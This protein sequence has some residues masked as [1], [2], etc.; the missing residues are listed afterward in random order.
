[1]VAF[2]LTSSFSEI[3][4]TQSTFP[5]QKGIFHTPP[6]TNPKFD[7]C[8]SVID[9]Y[10]TSDQ[11]F[12]SDSQTCYSIT[13]ENTTLITDDD[14]EREVNS[15]RE[16]PSELSRLVDFFISDLKQPKYSRPLNIEQLSSIFQGFYTKFDKSSFQYLSVVNVNG[17]NNSNVTTTFFNARETLCSGL[18]GLFARSRSSS[19]SSLMRARR[20][21]SLLNNDSNSVTPMLSPEEIKKQLKFNELLNLKIDK[22]MELCETEVFK[23]ILEVG[24]AVESTYLNEDKNKRSHSNKRTF[25]VSNLFKNS[26]EYGIYSKLLDRK[27]NCLCELDNE[28]RIDLKK[29]LDVPKGSL[30]VEFS[31]IE[32]ILQEIVCHS[33]SPCDKANLLL[34]LH[35]SMCYSQQMSND[36]FLS[37]LIYYLICSDTQNIFLNANFIRLFRYKKKMVKNELYVSTNLDAA[38]VFLESLT[39]SDFSKEVQDKLTDEEK[40]IFEVSISNRVDIHSNSNIGVDQI[41]SD[42][43][44]PNLDSSYINESFRSK[45]YDGL[46]SAFDTSLKNIFGRL[47]TY[48]PSTSISK[49]ASMTLLDV[50]K[51]LENDS[52]NSTIVLRPI[53]KIKVEDSWKKY[54]D[55]TFEN[56]LISEL[57]EIFTIYQ[58]V[59]NG[60]E[61]EDQ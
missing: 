19:A 4:E 20:S 16:L 49:S 46:K 14:I 23:R 43:T 40:N 42:H 21:S 33:I 38:L 7:T 6:I 61:I 10:K 25:R 28:G 2:D 35:S 36:E 39:L 27:M 37:L 58:A 26:P 22:Y 34:K 3:E 9:S 12:E 48:P 54:K 55:H 8:Q 17:T 32:E 59:V 18:S 52:G 53:P 44:Q 30:D 31:D 47:K 57:K 1:M 50:N 51:T 60:S 13:T 11:R 45:S 24:T 29:F 15:I 5:Y 41:N 56:L